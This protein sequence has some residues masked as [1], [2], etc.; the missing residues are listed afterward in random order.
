M[1]MNISNTCPLS[2]LPLRSG[3]FILYV[4][5]DENAKRRL[6]ELGFIKNTYLTPLFSSPLG[7]P[8]TYEIV[9]TV[10]AL[11]K[12]TADNIYVIPTKTNS[13]TEGDKI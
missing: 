8:R 2:E 13:P 7:D 6:A 11:R 12:E 10:V 9:G 4:G 3:A 1:D 5:G